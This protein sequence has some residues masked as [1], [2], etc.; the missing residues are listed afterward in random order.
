MR[1]I[2]V[3][4]ALFLGVTGIIGCASSERLYQRDTIPVFINPPINNPVPDIFDV[5]LE[6]KA[7]DPSENYVEPPVMPTLA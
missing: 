5:S 4:L 2:E 7:P 1:A 3:T 6:A